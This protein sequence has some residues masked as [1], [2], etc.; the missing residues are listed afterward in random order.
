[1]SDIV[2]A[3]KSVIG[4]ETDKFSTE[5]FFLIEAF[6]NNTGFNT[7]ELFNRSGDTIFVYT[8]MCI[9]VNKNII[10]IANNHIY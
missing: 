1:M 6:S 5:V 2:L 3:T 4:I 9:Y 8:Y 10:L 7:N